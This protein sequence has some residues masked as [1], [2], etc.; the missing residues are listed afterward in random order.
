MGDNLDEMD[1]L[2]FKQY[3]EEMDAE[4]AQALANGGGISGMASQQPADLGIRKA[5]SHKFGT[6]LGGPE[7][8]EYEDHSHQQ[9]NDFDMI[10][11]QQNYNMMGGGMPPPTGLGPQVEEQ[12]NLGGAQNSEDDLAKAIAASMEGM[13]GNAPADSDMDEELARALEMSKNL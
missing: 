2:I 9:H 3:M 8:D 1:Q 4:E 5:D 12:M 10:G 13:G 7:E 6:L 11:G